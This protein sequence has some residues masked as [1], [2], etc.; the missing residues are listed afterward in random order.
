MKYAGWHWMLLLFLNVIM[1]LNSF[2][3]IHLHGGLCIHRPGIEMNVPNFPVLFI[4]WGAFTYPIWHMIEGGA[5]VPS[6]FFLCHSREGIILCASLSMANTCLEFF[7]RSSL[8]IFWYCIWDFSLPLRIT[9]FFFKKCILCSTK[10]AQS[11]DNSLCPGENHNVGAC[12]V[13]KP[14]A[15]KACSERASQKK[16]ALWEKASSVQKLLIV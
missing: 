3:F 7:I 8:S 12:A 5:S 10:V 15:S 13:C 1:F 11:D 9:L 4:V 16:A 6:L 14:T 2:I